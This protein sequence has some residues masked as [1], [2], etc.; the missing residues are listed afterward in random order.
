MNCKVARENELYEKYL[1]HQLDK[2]ETEAFKAHFKKCV[3][4]RNELSEQQRLISGLRAIGRQQ[5]KAEIREQVPAREGRSSVSWGMAL[6]VA[7]VLFIVAL[8]PTILKLYRQAQPFEPQMAVLPSET[9]S[10]VVPPPDLSTE[11]D[12]ANFA[13]QGESNLNLRGNESVSTPGTAS[14][15]SAEA[16]LRKSLAESELSEAQRLDAPEKLEASA[17]QQKSQ[18]EPRM[19]ETMNRKRKSESSAMPVMV[20]PVEPRSAEPKASPQ[21]SRSTAVSELSFSSLE[22]AQ[23][24]S[25][26]QSPAPA[27]QNVMKT[28]TPS[29]EQD[30]SLRD[31]SL[32]QAV[33]GTAQDQSGLIS[34]QSPQRNLTVTVKLVSSVGDTSTGFPETFTVEAVQQDA[35]LWQMLWHLP[36]E[37]AK[38]DR[39]S[40]RIQ[41]KNSSLLVKFGSEPEYEIPLQT[42]KTV[43]RKLK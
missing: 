5:M 6:K 3:S 28:F 30:V 34:W 1:L 10:K 12:A 31:H 43:A 39:K 26:R 11:E 8:T 2:V 18:A 25:K 7:A 38:L 4:C 41:Q 13:V 20:E 24:V 32:P 22:L 40:V 37:M 33:S 35:G 27:E 42:G 36:V 14:N 29:G 23:G 17:S 16:P 15:A 21:T 9:E 19:E